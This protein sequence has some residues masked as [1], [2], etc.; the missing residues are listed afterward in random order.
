MPIRTTRGRAGAYR[1]MWQWPLRSPARLALTVAA[2][3]A[4]GVGVG[5]GA[6][7]AGGG[8]DRAGLPELPPRPSSRVVAP[9]TPEVGG[10]GTPASTALPPAPQTTTAPLSEAPT[11]ALVVASRWAT[12]WVRPPEG[13]TA[14]EWR[15]GLRATTTQEYLGVLGSVDPTNIPS[16]V[17]TGQPRPVLVSDGSV[18]AEVPTDAVTLLVLVVETETGWRVAGYDRVGG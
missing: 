4:V 15:E 10:P 12:A 16:T 6:P 7:A 3:V 17:V 1:G 8:A 5:V 11:A 9:R 13:T 2:V 14:E 18:Q